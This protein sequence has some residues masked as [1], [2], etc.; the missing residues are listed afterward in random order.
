M[1]LAL[2]GVFSGSA[3][4]S[5]DIG[6]APAA[7][8]IVVVDQEALYS[9]SL[10][11]QRVQASYLAESSALAEEN[12]RMEAELSEEEQR[13]TDLRPTLEPSEFRELA[14]SFDDRVNEARQ[15][16]DRKARSLSERQNA[17]RQTFFAAVLPVLQQLM[18]ERG[19]SAMFDRR[20]LLISL[21]NLDIT[22]DAINEIDTVLGDGVEAILDTQTTTT[23]PDQ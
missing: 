8:G 21:G 16:Q 18:Q 12:R 15:S 7:P 14:Q 5:Q 17:E 6:S 2:F 13:L 1:A 11:G 9:Q 4:V 3:A 23:V 20:A 22:A 19:A 10:F